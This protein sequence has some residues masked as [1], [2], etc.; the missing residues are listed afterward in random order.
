[1]TTVCAGCGHANRDG[2]R[3]CLECGAELPLACASCGAALPA[4]AHFCD[5]C[6]AAVA[7]S[8]VPTATRKVITVV[9][10]DLVGS[11][12]LQETLDPESARGV[13]SRF[14]DA[15]RA[16]VARHGGEIPHFSGDGVLAVFGTPLV[17][18]DD[19]LRAVRCAAAM[20]ADLE[21]LGEELERTWGV[22]LQMR[23][24]VNT[25]E[26][27]VS[28]EGELVG[29]TMNTAARLEQAAAAGEVLVGEATWRLVRHD[30][31]L[32]AVEPLAL[33]GKAEPVRAFRLV[34]TTP[35]D[36]VRA[37][38][39]LVGRH[40]ELL[41]LRAA[42]DG[43]LEARECRLAT[44]IGWP[45][46]GKTRLADEFGRAVGDVA[47]VVVGHCEQSGEGITF[48]PVA[49]VLREVAGIGETDPPDEVRSKLAALIPD[50][51]PERERLVERS[52]G[53]LGVAEPASAQETFWAL[54]RGLEF[55]ARAQPLV[56]VL[57]DVQW[58]EP[59]FL[60]LIE[61]L[62]EWAR[63]APVLILALARPELRDA[64]E[65]L[66]VPGQRA[67]EVIDLGPLDEDECRALVTGVLGR[68]ELP[69][70]LSERI[71]ST[72]EGNP[73]FIGELLRMLVD[74]GALR[75]EGEVW[76]PAGDLAD[77][78]VPPTI[79]ALLAARIERLRADE[80]SVVERAAVIG[81][82]FYRG[83]VAELVAP[84]VRSGIDDHL[85]AL[86][87]KDM[88]EPE[89]TYWIDEPVYRFHHVLI[90]DAAY[91]SLLKEARAEL[92]ERFAAWLEE[93]AG[94]LVGEHEEVVAFHLE[95]AF[96][97][98]RQLGPLDDRG[99]A[100]G[101]RAAA[102]LHSTGRRALARADLAAASNLLGRAL[103]C[104]PGDEG[105]VLWDLGEALL[106]AGDTAASAPVVERLR[107]DADDPGRD[108][109]AEVLAAQLANLTGAGEIAATADT[110]A[111]ATER[112][113]GLGDRQGEAKGHHV[114]A[115]TLARLGRVG[116]VEAALDRGLAAA[117]AAD[118]RRRIT[119]VLAGAPRAALWGPSPVVRA[120]GRC[121]DVVRILRMTP[122]NRHVEAV[123][124]RCQAVLEA[125][126][127]RADA[128]R[129]ILAA[130]RATLEE[131]GLALELHETAIHAGIVELLA[132]DPAAAERH[133]RAARDGYLELGV[134]AGAAHAAAI[135]ARAL[136]DQGRDAEALEETQL[137]EAHGGEDLKTTITWCGVRAEALAHGG[138]HEEALSFAERA[139]ALAEPTDGLPD[140]ADA[141]MALTRV[142]L[143]AGRVAEAREA[144]A[145]ARALYE[146]KGHAVGAERAAALAT[147][148]HKAA[149]QPDAAASAARA[150][151]PEPV[152]GDS[153]P[154]RFFAEFCRAFAVH[155]V[156]ALLE[157]RTEDWVQVDHRKVGWEE[158]HGREAAEELI[159][160]AFAIAPDM[161]LDVD[162]V[163]AC[164]ERSCVL[165]AAWRGTSTE[166]KGEFSIPI[167]VVA[168]IED[169]RLAREELYE[170]ED[171]QEMIAR[172][173]ELGGGQAPLGTRPPERLWAEFCRRFAAGDLDGMLV[174]YTEDS[175]LTDHRRLPWEGVSG[176]GGF[177]E[178]IRSYLAVASDQWLGIDAV[179][180]CDDRVIALRHTWHGS[181]V[182]GGG[183][184]AV[185]V[186]V[187]AVVESG[188]VVSYDQY[189][190]ED[191]DA[192]LA[193]YAELGG[194][195]PVDVGDRP[196][197]R[198]VRAVVE[199]YAAR[200]LPR[201]AALAKPDLA[202]VD[203]RSMSYN[204]TLGRTSWEQQTRSILESAPDLRLDLDEVLA[205]DD[206]VIAFRS[207][208]RGHGITAG[209]FEIPFASVEVVEDGMLASVDVYEPDDRQ[210]MI[211]RYA[212]LGGGQAPLGERPPERAWRR[213]A[214]A[215]AAR[216]M[217]ALRELHADGF[218]FADHRSM[219]WD[220]H[221]GDIRAVFEVAA[222]VRLEVHEVLACDERIIAVRIAWV[223][224]WLDGGGDFAYPVGVVSAVESARLTTWDQY[225]HGD[226][227]AMLARYAELGG[228]REAGAGAPAAERVFAEHLRRW[229]A[230]DLDAIVGL[231]AEDFVLTDHRPIGWEEVRGLAALE[232]FVRSVLAAS[233]DLHGAIEEILACDE[234]VVA[235][236]AVWGGSSAEG[237]GDIEFRFGYVT[238][239]EKGL[240]AHQE[241]F[242]AND[243]DAMLARYA[244]LGG[245][246]PAPL[247]DR[248]PER[249]LAE[250]VRRWTARDLDAIVD[251]FSGD[252]VLEDH[253]GLGWDPISG[254]DAQREVVRSG[255]DMS[256]DIKFEVQEVLACDERVM[257]TAV[258]YR[259]TAGEGGGPFELPFGYVFTAED[260]RATR[261]DVYDQGDRQ[262]MLA[263]YAELGGGQSP[264][265]DRPPERFMAEFARRW[266][267][268]DAARIADLYADDWVGTEHRKLGWEEL[269]RADVDEH[270]RSV[271]SVSPELHV[272]IDEVLACD[273]RLIALRYTFVGR[274]GD[275]G[276]YENAYGNVIRLGAGRMTSLDRYEPDDREAM[277]ARFAELA[278][279][280][281]LGDSAPERF[282]A[283]YRRRNATHDVDHLVELFS[284][285]YVLHD[286]RAM[287]WKETRGREALRRTIRGAFEVQPDI[288]TEV[289]EVL[290]CDERVIAMRW[291]LRGH[292]SAE[293]GGGPV[294]IALGVVATVEEGL[295]VS[296]DYYESDDD[297]A[298][299]A[300]YAELGGGGRSEDLAARG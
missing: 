95:Q 151:I 179:L 164:D 264:L 53:V 96:D 102:R 56:L 32:E 266:A 243:R 148:R 37:E 144:A 93:K 50:D 185:P 117:R 67:T 180:A 110:V 258:L 30:V 207:T 198:L 42:L 84:P 94:D 295:W 254:H 92:H 13:M 38:P 14:Y 219:G 174:L 197:E 170:P 76:V 40:A 7:P 72:A 263:R 286:H 262:A 65:A 68:A 119:A 270:V 183:E 104:E 193:C 43:V 112:L 108:A 106:S 111:A 82:Q 192:M 237:G 245:R 134:A 142:L 78:E 27:V 150:E 70:T 230:R 191:R 190:P 135:L 206:R 239:V 118:D 291:L 116:A 194:R 75:R 277:L 114:T 97:Y 195:R 85:E 63:D 158:R 248:P 160:S 66:T 79:H 154:E 90:R 173:A 176:S 278:G 147:A 211:A 271:L 293:E 299:I 101:T 196:P 172:F 156:D 259:G 25:G 52:A 125:M 202:I 163:I 265:G 8:E 215:Y 77:V 62:V 157:L 296:A 2:A 205:C 168:V 236:T 141:S 34:S 105:A 130:G 217:T 17:R 69:E 288:D 51:E 24:G 153:P 231:C 171:R 123:A 250:F 225:G 137:A 268:R 15:M 100:L 98:R 284:P 255:L 281:V 240:I 22:R 45:G 83:A 57:D 12:A 233:P 18:E 128:A 199:G 58:G 152:L 54:R 10:G 35:A 282:F 169:G 209:P 33:K 87:R 188:R 224:T 229:T 126:R 276:L 241:L 257:A 89:G 182:E 267:G 161:R 246:R 290:A 216:D 221:G 300:R 186:G 28:G 149:T 279:E 122:G 162:E 280:P 166:G 3:F 21:L 226:R 292:W 140:K 61:H 80:R 86:R 124:L 71:V 287:G 285:E 31:E 143:A 212:E 113:A 260:G 131:L 253:R 213:F 181:S 138:E 46:V 26:L 242:E 55:L 155:D 44:V 139:V 289:Q 73:L 91:R 9:F 223:G 269:R 165:A 132:G 204:E 189:E 48:L 39:A 115:Q 88:V 203:H 247:G 23:T 146:E 47:R 121:L 177:A 274:A 235:A 103:G 74:E 5:A 133:L 298:M 238:V 99:H 251:L 81:K 214:V 244:E 16:A 256:P 283:E 297:A 249:F 261:V 232:E 20:V 29:D 136:V 294:E 222:D 127:G 19:A 6:G 208:F 167:G 201:L 275:G 109:R 59:M 107:G 175:S 49:E 11:T 145:A 187:V 273:E 210:A 228:V 4:G 252:Y 36:A 64:R 200:D 272:E 120:S 41:R 60:D 178:L 1:M 218:E 129:E 234:R 227:E 159:R 184:T 220:A